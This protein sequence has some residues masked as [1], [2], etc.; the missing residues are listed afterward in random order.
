MRRSII[1]FCTLALVF[2]GAGEIFAGSIDYVSNQSVEYIRTMNRNAATDAADVVNYNPAGVTKFKDGLFLNV[3]NQTALKEYTQE[4]T[5]ATHTWN[6]KAYTS[7]VPTWSVPSF[8]AVYKQDKWAAFAAFTVPGGGGELEFDGSVPYIRTAL[9]GA[10]YLQAQPYGATI[11][12]QMADGVVANIDKLTVSS[13][14]LAGTIGGA[15]A[16]N[17]IMSLSLGCRYIT[18]TKKITLDAKQSN[19]LLTDGTTIIDL[20][21]EAAGVGGVIGVDITPMPELNIGVRYETDTKLEWDTT[22]DGG[23]V[24]AD[25]AG[26]LGYKDGEVERK[27]LPG[28]VGLG[29]EYK[30]TPELAVTW[31]MTYYFIMESTWRHYNNEQADL[32]YHNGWETGIAFAYKVMPEL[33]ASIGYNYQYAGGNENTLNA[34]DMTLDSNT[35][36]LGCK[37]AIMPELNIN[38]GMCWAMYK[39]AEDV[40]KIEY[41]KDVK[42]IAIGVEYKAM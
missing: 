32:G 25:F 7:D 19:P 27:D 22:V 10:T 17:D 23:P 8:F 2:L 1:F 11:A 35:V 14:Y 20:G 15:Y 12:A 9:W 3:T 21:L 18:A 34:V 13:M 5:D 40:N 28:L 33:E 39:D 29:V 26:Q 6:T 30:V 38:L 42:L 41:S 36:G 24:A 4:D 31:G 16:I 37:Y